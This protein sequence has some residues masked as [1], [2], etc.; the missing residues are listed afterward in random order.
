MANVIRKAGAGGKNR[1]IGFLQGHGELSSK[2]TADI[3][4]ELETY[5]TV[6]DVAFNLS[7]KETI[8][9]FQ[10]KLERSA[11]PEKAI[12]KELLNHLNGFKGLIMAKPTQPFSKSRSIYIR[13]IYHERG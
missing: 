9:P 2:A 12:F 3:R 8:L 13:P 7:K 11:E 5:Y 4:K 1:K 6:R 10:A